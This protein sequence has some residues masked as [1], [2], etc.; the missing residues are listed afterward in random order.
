MGGVKVKKDERC[1]KVHLNNEK[2][3]L[4]STEMGKARHR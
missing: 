4:L 2:D 3:E 1:T